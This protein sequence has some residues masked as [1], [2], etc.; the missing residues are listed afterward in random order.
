MSIK[1]RMKTV[2]VL[3]PLSSTSTLGTNTTYV[4]EKEILASISLS[5]G[6]TATTNN[7]I[8]TSSTHTALTQDRTITRNHRL[9]DGDNV[10]KIEYVNNDGRLYS[11][12]FLSLVL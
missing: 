12:L 11:V 6:T 7:T 1:G 9:K 4:P 5:N 8:Y 2:E 10:Y 3:K